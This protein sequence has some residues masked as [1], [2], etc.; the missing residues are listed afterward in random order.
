MVFLTMGCAFGPG[1]DGFDVDPVPLEMFLDL[2][3]SA[4]CE[5]HY[6]C[7]DDPGDALFLSMEDCVETVYAREAPTLQDPACG[8]SEVAAGMC[9][10]ELEERKHTCEQVVGAC[11]GVCRP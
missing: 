2:Y 1:P 8:Y 11:F 10:A 9:L 4:W 7:L 6:A 5:Q 3:P